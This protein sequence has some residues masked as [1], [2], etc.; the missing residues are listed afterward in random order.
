MTFSGTA[1]LVAPAVQGVR[2]CGVFLT[3]SRRAAPPRS[4]SCQ[5]GAAVFLLSLSLRTERATYENTTA[6][7]LVIRSALFHT[8]TIS[9]LSWHSTA[10]D[11]ALQRCLAEQFYPYVVLGSEQ[12]VKTQLDNMHND[13]N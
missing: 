7:R 5:L 8:A 3:L 6:E 10:A 1:L 12:F 11:V 9:E 13:I 2:A 4:L